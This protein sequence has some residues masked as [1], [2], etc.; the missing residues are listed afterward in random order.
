[1]KELLANPG[2]AI[3]LIIAILI[4]FNMALTGLKKGLEYIADKTATDVD[5]KALVIVNK[6]AEVL[7]KI[8]D[9]IG[10]NPEH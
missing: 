6:I 5:N 4:A 1:M 3:A 9:I 10:H 8:I 2:A 7:Q